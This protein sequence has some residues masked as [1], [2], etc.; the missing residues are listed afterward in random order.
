MAGSFSLTQWSV[1][2]NKV[3]GH[4]HFQKNQPCQDAIAWQ[5]TDQYVVLAV[6]DGHGSDKCP[7]SEDG[8]DIAVQ[9]MI[10]FLKKNINNFSMAAGNRFYDN[11]IEKMPA[12]I[13]KNWSTEVLKFHKEEQR[14]PD[15]DSKILHKYGSTLL[16]A[17]VTPSYSFLAQIGDGDLLVLT[18]EGTIIRPFERDERLIA[19]QTTSLCNS[20]AASYFNIYFRQHGQSPL[21]LMLMLSTDGYSNSYRSE[22]GFEHVVHDYWHM[23]TE[24]G[25]DRVAES[26]AGFLAETS[27][28]GSGDDIS[29]GL[30]INLPM[31]EQLRREVNESTL[32]N[33]TEHDAEQRSNV[34]SD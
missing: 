30:I 13:V 11:V 3:R 34:Q 16:A 22:E 9:T 31:L 2:G 17:M 1:I 20:N 10:S 32:E 25:T 19:N 14:E 5:V 28:D 29:L 26:L 33:R 21:P 12:E 6:A 27:R 7:Y 23:L 18:T 24:H 8:S 4:S 15:V